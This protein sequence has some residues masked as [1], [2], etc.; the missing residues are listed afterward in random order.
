LTLRS[1]IIQADAPSGRG[2][3]LTLESHNASSKAMIFFAILP[4]SFTAEL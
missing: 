2:S 3:T 1:N 4:N